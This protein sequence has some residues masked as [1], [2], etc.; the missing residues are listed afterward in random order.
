MKLE[1]LRKIADELYWDIINTD[2]TEFDDNT[3]NWIVEDFFI[4]KLKVTVDDPA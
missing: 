3:I 4:E 2:Y 1:E